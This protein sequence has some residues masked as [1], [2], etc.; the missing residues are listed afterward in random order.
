LLLAVC[1]HSLVPEMREQ[2]VIRRN[3]RHYCL[4]PLL[5]LLLLQLELRLVTL[6]QMWKLISEKVD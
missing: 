4:L 3:A 2:W 1:T 5:P 6:L